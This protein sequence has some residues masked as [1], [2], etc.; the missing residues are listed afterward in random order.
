ML[1][2][3]SCKYFYSVTGTQHQPFK[4]FAPTYTTSNTTDPQLIFYI[5]V[6]PFGI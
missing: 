2:S 4:A 1:Q 5:G 6:V 3:F